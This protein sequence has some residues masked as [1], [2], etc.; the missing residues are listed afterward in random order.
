MVYYKK[1]FHTQYLRYDFALFMMQCVALCYSTALYNQV[2]R[3]CGQLLSLVLEQGES[4]SVMFSAH[5]LI[6]LWLTVPL[7]RLATPIIVVTIKTLVSYASL[8]LVG[9]R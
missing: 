4:G 6:S 3:L 7:L 1:P 5:W 9:Y 2:R 8:N